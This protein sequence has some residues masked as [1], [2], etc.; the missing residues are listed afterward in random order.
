[1]ELEAAPT[2]V[3]PRPEPV[4]QG[5]EISTAPARAEIAPSSSWVEV[6]S[7]ITVPVEQSA[8]RP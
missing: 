4:M 2:A 3:M 6:V 5:S 7:V 8:P 1:V